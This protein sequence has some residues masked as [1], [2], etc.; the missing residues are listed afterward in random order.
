MP[1][2]EIILENQPI[3]PK[4]KYEYQARLIKG[5]NKFKWSLVFFIKRS[6]G[7]DATPGQWYATTILENIEGDKLSIDLGLNWFVGNIRNI[8]KEILEKI[9]NDIEIELEIE[10]EQEIDQR[11]HFLERKKIDD[12]ERE[13]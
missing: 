6:D 5:D 8:R 7:W 11:K 4:G 3:D 1:R 10:T 2:K 13:P 9:G 12:F